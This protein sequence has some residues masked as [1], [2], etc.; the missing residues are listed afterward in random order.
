MSNDLEAVKGHQLFIS[1]LVHYSF[2]CCISDKQSC[3]FSEL[4]I[5]MVCCLVLAFKYC[6][7]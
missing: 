1:T 5:R 3:C 2:V 6:I 4:S 7:Q